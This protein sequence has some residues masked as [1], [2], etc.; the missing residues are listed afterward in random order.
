MV[1]LEIKRGPLS[2]VTVNSIDRVI[3]ENTSGM[4]ELQDEETKQARARSAT[5]EK[6]AAKGQLTAE[7]KNKRFKRAHEYCRAVAPRRIKD[8]SYY[9][10]GSGHC[11]WQTDNDGEQV[12]RLRQVGDP[13]YVEIRTSDGQTPTAARENTGTKPYNLCCPLIGSHWQLADFGI[14]VGLYYTML[15]VWMVFLALLF[16]INTPAMFCNSQFKFKMAEYKTCRNFTNGQ[17]TNGVGAPLTWT[18]DAVY[19]GAPLG[20]TGTTAV[21]SKNGDELEKSFSQFCMFTFPNNL[22]LWDNWVAHE[23]Y[24]GVTTGS[25]LDVRRFD[26]GGSLAPVT[27]L[28]GVT[29]CV[30]IFCMIILMV[31][32]RRFEKKVEIRFDEALQTVSWCCCGL[33]FCIYIYIVCI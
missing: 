6:H 16:I 8:F 28:Q 10:D 31:A 13:E 7:A 33:F 12:W 21:I 20:M 32:L 22:T 30:C 25:K 5:E 24:V 4:A 19:C 26:Y 2:S 29:E 3:E 14:G 23:D 15:I 27:M 17:Q 11:R 9:K 18:Q 1:L